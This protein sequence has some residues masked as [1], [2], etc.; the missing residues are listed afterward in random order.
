MGFSGANLNPD[1]NFFV[2]WERCPVTGALDPEPIRRFLA[3]DPTPHA[4]ER[5]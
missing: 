1:L 3:C 2:P 4:E 5:I